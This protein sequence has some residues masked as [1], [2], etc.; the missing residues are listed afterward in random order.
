MTIAQIQHAI[1]VMYSH[2]SLNLL[3]FRMALPL[4]A[5]CVYSVADMSK[6]FSEAKY[7]K[8]ELVKTSFVKW[9]TYSG[10]VPSP[11]PG[12]VSLTATLHACV[13]VCMREISKGYFFTSSAA[14]S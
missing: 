1:S 4:S 11:R 10:D 2:T 7:K 8:P 9:V 6:V 13:C 14:G 3:S 12:A 5:V